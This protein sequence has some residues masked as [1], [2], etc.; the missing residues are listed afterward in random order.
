MAAASSRQASN[1]N[2]NQNNVPLHKQTFQ[3]KDILKKIEKGDFILV[4]KKEFLKDPPK[5]MVWNV[6]K[7]ICDK[8]KNDL[9]CYVRTNKVICTKTTTC[10]QLYSF[11]TGSGTLLKHIQAH[12]NDGQSTITTSTPSTFHL[13]QHYKKKL[14]Q[15]TL[16]TIGLD[17]DHFNV[18]DKEGMNQQLT[19]IWNLG[20]HFKQTIN[21]KQMKNM[22]MDP[23]TIGRNIQKKGEEIRQKIIQKMKYIIDKH[24][25]AP[26]AMTTDMW[27]NTL[28]MKEIFGVIIHYLDDGETETRSEFIGFG[29][30]DRYF[31]EAREEHTVQQLE[32]VDV[33]EKEIE[34]YD[35]EG[36]N[37]YVIHFM[38]NIYIF[39]GGFSFPRGCHGGVQEKLSPESGS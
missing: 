25:P 8:D 22:I 27:T 7:V 34:E 28:T 31:I 18:F 19:L 30:F 2:H 1:D 5:S 9:D 35:S 6:F 39:L 24:Y 26:I 23:T 16:K 20:A 17:L 37:G 3:K 12:E 4:H 14:D 15:Q 13:G 32:T 11:N 29:D 33:D 10:T 38:C 36:S 21:Q